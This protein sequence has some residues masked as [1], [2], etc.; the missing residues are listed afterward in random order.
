MDL[1]R[2]L[3]RLP[4]APAARGTVDGRCIVAMASRSIA[5]TASTRRWSTCGRRRSSMSSLAAASTCAVLATN[6]CTCAS[7]SLSVC[8]ACPWLTVRCNSTASRW[9]AQRGPATSR[10]TSRS[11]RAASPTRRGASAA[12]RRSRSS[13]ARASAG[14]TSNAP[15]PTSRTWPAALPAT[16]RAGRSVGGAAVM[17]V[18]ARRFWRAGWSPDPSPCATSGSGP[19]RRPRRQVHPTHARGR[20]PQRACCAAR[21]RCR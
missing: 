1:A 2:R 5:W 9:A 4:P 20:Y 21:P 17:E 12:C 8:S 7:I 18:V 6:E 16:Q 19:P 11:P 10:A 14:A 15:P 3:R 13:A